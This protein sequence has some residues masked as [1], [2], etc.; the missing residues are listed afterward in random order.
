SRSM[1][2]GVRSSLGVAHGYAVDNEMVPG[3]LHFNEERATASR[4]SADV[5]GIVIGRRSLRHAL[6]TR[7]CW[8]GRIVGRSG[9]RGVGKTRRGRRDETIR[10]E[11]NSSIIGKSTAEEELATDET[12][13]IEEWRADRAGMHEHTRVAEVATPPT[14]AVKAARHPAA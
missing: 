12:P 5:A 1:G 13:V 7:G 9:V 14:A 8:I 4:C 10:A 11:E 2:E 6:I 3:F